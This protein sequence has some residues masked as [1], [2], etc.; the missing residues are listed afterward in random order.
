MKRESSM[1][2]QVPEISIRRA[3][4]MLKSNEGSPVAGGVSGLLRR[5]DLFMQKPND[6]LGFSPIQRTKGPRKIMKKEDIRY[7]LDK[8]RKGVSKEHLKM[9]VKEANRRKGFINQEKEII[10]MKY[11]SDLGNNNTINFHVEKL[12]KNLGKKQNVLEDIIKDSLKQPSVQFH[13]CD[14]L[15]TDS[16]ITEG[17]QKSGD[18]YIK[19]TSSP[20]QPHRHSHQCEEERS[21]SITQHAKVSLVH[22]LTSAQNLTHKR[23]HPMIYKQDFYSLQNFINKIQHEKETIEKKLG[24]VDDL[25]QSR[26]EYQEHIEELATRYN[27]K[28]DKSQLLPFQVRTQ[29]ICVNPQ[30]FHD[31]K[32]NPLHLIEDH[33]ERDYKRSKEPGF[34]L[35]GELNMKKEEL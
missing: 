11:A 26:K 1:N 25:S 24:P 23:K 8:I 32:Q 27:I 17:T 6:N 2:I 28:I 16:E 9:L 7:N 4:T 20:N 22:I 3:S 33:E 14:H 13:A 18:Y 5:Q 19:T 31:Y 29:Q 12:Y 30:A 10:E 15:E 21:A 34:D 35:A